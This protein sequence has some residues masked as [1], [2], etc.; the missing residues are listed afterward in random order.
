MISTIV[1][2][3]KRHKNISVYLSLPCR[4]TVGECRY[5][6]IKGLIIVGD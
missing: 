6:K 1:R 4:D 5:R 3:E 2:F